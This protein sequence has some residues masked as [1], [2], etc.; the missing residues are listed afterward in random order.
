MNQ[1]IIDFLNRHVG[2]FILHGRCWVARMRDRASGLTLHYSIYP[3]GGDATRDYINGNGQPVRQDRIDVAY[4]A[5]LEAR[6]DFLPP[7]RRVPVSE[8]RQWRDIL[9]T[10]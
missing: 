3:R 2:I 5:N 6:Y 8:T 10:P 1:A 7:P 9:T 4:L